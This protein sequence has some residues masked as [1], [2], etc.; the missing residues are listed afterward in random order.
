[1]DREAHASVCF[2]QN[3]RWLRD[4]PANLSGDNFMEKQSQRNQ[5]E[6]QGGCVIC[7]FSWGSGCLIFLG[8]L[9]LSPFEDFSTAKGSCILTGPRVSLPSTAR[10][11]FTH[12]RGAPRAGWAGRGK[13][14]SPPPTQL[15]VPASQSHGLSLLEPQFSHLDNGNEAHPLLLHLVLS[16]VSAETEEVRITQHTGTVFIFVTEL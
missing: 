10:F 12:P 4:S 6:K 1:M 15:R 9:P 2:L 13:A 16:R 3:F 5:L 7:H 8:R 11:P 14:W